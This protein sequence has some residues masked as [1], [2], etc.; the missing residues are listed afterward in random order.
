[1]R[2]CRADHPRCITRRARC[3]RRICHGR[4]DRSGSTLTMSNAKIPSELSQPTPRPVRA[5]RNL[6]FF[7]AIATILAAVATTSIIYKSNMNLTISIVFAAAV[8]LLIFAV[9]GFVPVLGSRQ[10]RRLLETGG[11]A[12]AV[13]VERQKYSTPRHVRAKVIY[14]FTNGNGQTY[15]GVRLGLPVAALT[16][17]PIADPRIA[18][19]LADP[20]VIYDRDDPKINMLYPFDMVEIAK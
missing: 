5:R 19:M 6:G 20:T 4:T 9:L 3:H 18:A 8:D 14:E 7:F 2:G 13:I 1:M 10:Q 12:T 15:R 16:G 11:V 17:G